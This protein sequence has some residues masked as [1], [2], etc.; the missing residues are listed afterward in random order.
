MPNGI[1]NSLSSMGE[2]Q[3]RNPD[4]VPPNGE[5]C[6]K[7]ADRYSPASGMNIET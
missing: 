4:A 5:M 6:K 7:I 1:P 3:F 2:A